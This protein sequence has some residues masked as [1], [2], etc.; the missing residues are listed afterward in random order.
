[1]S[2][3][4]WRW[5][6]H[7]RSL[8]DVA[9]TC[10]QVSLVFCRHKLR[11]VNIRD[12]LD[13]WMYIAELSRSFLAVMGYGCAVEIDPVA[14]E[15]A[16]VVLIPLR[17]SIEITCDGDRLI[18]MHGDAVTIPPWSRLHMRLSED[19][20]VIV[21]WIDSAALDDELAAILGQPAAEAFQ[22]LS[23]MDLAGGRG[24]TWWRTLERL[25]AQPDLPEDR[26]ISQDAVCKVEDMLL[27]GLL[28]AQDESYR[29]IS[30]APSQAESVSKV[31]T[32][33]ALMK[34][35]PTWTISAYAR[36]VGLSVSALQRGFEEYLGVT[37]SRFRNRRRMLCLRDELLHSSRSVTTVRAAAQR[38][39]F[40]Y[41]TSFVRRYRELFG[42]YPGETLRRTM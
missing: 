12:R 15:S 24:C 31:W 16:Y 19:A 33:V 23:Y 8:H 3:S 32:A 37:L 14:R 36:D 2:G 4:F 21:F 42:E 13:A 11:K 39:G 17:G 38:W 6:E 10:Y 40:V 27:R 29:K 28:M 35:D 1:M 30:M 9:T 20:K 41:S 26:Q 25:L 7:F 18:V 34:K 5:T 22:R